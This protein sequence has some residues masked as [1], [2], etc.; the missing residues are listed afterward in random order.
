M[1]ELKKMN[2]VLKSLMMGVAAMALVGTVSANQWPRQD[3]KTSTWNIVEKGGTKQVV[4]SDDFKTKAAPDLKIF[5]STNTVDGLTGANP[6]KGSVLVAKLTS[7]K[8]GQSYA[9][10]AGVDLSKYKTI[11]IHCEKFSK[12]WSAAPLR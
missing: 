1:K 5:L 9:I 11:I 4:L 2:R 8:G 10:P 12:L 6:T 7:S 3:Y